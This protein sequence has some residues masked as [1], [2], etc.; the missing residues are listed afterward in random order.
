MKSVS[1]NRLSVRAPVDSSAWEGGEASA[2]PLPTA[3]KISGPW[4]ISDCQVPQSRS[5]LRL[6]LKR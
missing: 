3:S 6:L 2:M 4:A 1:R 5:N